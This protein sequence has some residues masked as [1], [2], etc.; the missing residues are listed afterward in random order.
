MREAIPPLPQYVFMAWC[1]V[2]HRDNSTFTFYI[3]IIIIIIFFS[4]IGKYS[5]SEFN[6]NCIIIHVTSLVKKNNYFKQMFHAIN[7]WNVLITWL[8]LH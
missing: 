2:K 5:V 7:C 6:E 3:I 8:L 4:T 1:L